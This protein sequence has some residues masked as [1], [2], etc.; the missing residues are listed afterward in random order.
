[1]LIKNVLHN[2]GENLLNIVFNFVRIIFRLILYSLLHLMV[3][4]ATRPLEMGL[5]YVSSVCLIPL[6]LL[7]LVSYRQW[8]SFRAQN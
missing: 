7:F 2:P 1:M 5:Q 3:S 6:N 4:W 8:L